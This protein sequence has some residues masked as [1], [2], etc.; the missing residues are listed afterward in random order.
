MTESTKNKI[1]ANLEQAKQEGQLRAE[2]IKEIVKTAVSQAVAEFKEG[3]GEIRSL[4]KDAIAA[5]IETFQEKSGDLKEEITASIEGVVEGISSG[6]QKAIS[7][8][9][10][11]IKQ[12]EGSIEVEE[13]KLQKE[14]DDALTDIK[15]TG[16]SQ[17]DKI[18]SA[19]ESAIETIR[20]SEE[21]ELLQ[22][23]Y[24]QLRAQLAVV[25]ANLASRYGERN[26]NIQH[27][28]DEAKTWYNRA[29][30]EPEVFTE[31]VKQKRAQFEEKLG[32]AATALVK[33][34]RKIK[35]L[36]QELWREIKD[37]FHEK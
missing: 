3:S 6:K 30:E 4:A 25:Q 17:S 27:Y 5:T 1:A 34:E 8:R 11:E 28:L 29:L 13:T 22:K 32:T 10:T 21:V 33:R 19:I 35:Q 24:A 31:P 9:Q 26:E 7:E 2:K 14:I 37:I 12:L 15:S 20:N 36:L 23:R 16:V 18:Q